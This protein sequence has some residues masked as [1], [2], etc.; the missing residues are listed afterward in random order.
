MGSCFPLFLLEC[1][2]SPRT[3]LGWTN[4]AFL[5]FLGDDA[6]SW[7][8]EMNNHWRHVWLSSLLHPKHFSELLWS[9][10]AGKLPSHVSVHWVNVYNEEFFLLRP[11]LAGGSN[12]FEIVRRAVRTRTYSE[13]IRRALTI[14]ASLHSSDGMNDPN[15]RGLKYSPA[16]SPLLQS[17]VVSPPLAAKRWAPSRLRIFL[18]LARSWEHRGRAAAGRNVSRSR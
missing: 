17:S 13:R 15:V 16:L 11:L 6:K 4:D 3:S 7:P 5:T 1:Y 14:Q 9:E 8:H 2:I 12:G 10:Y 18:A